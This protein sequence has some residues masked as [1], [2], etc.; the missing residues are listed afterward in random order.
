MLWNAESPEQYTLLLET[1]DECICQKIGLRKIEIKDGVVYLNGVAIKFRGVNRH[2]SDPVTGAAISREQALVDLALMKRHNINAIR[3][4]HYPN[5]PWFLQ[6][7]SEYGF[8]VIA[9]A[10][11]ESHGMADQLGGRDALE[12][13]PDAADDPQFKEAILDRARRSVIRDKNNAAVV[14]WSLG[15]E[16]GWGENFEVAGRWVKSYD[17]SRLLHYENFLTYHS[18]RKPDISMIDLYSRMYPSVQFVEDYFSGCELDENLEGRR[19]PLI[20]CEYVHAMGNGPGD[21]EDYQQLIMEHDGFCGGFVWE[22]CDHAVYGGTTSD[23]R[24]IYRYGGDFGEYPHDGNFCMDGL[25]Y[26]DRTPHRGLL[27]YKNCIRP[28]RVREAQEPNSFILHNYLDFT[29]AEDFAQLSYEVMQDGEILYGGNIDM[30]HIPPHGEARIELFDLP[31]DGIA[32]VTFF[33]TA[34]KDGDF[35]PAGHPL[36]FDE[37]I[38]SDEPFFLDEPVQGAVSVE[39]SARRISVFS[40]GFRYEFDKFTGLFESMV[41]K[42]K[43]LLTRPMQWNIY[44][45]PTDND[46]LMAPKWKA[47]GYDRATVKVYDTKVSSTENGVQISLHA[48]IAAVAIKRIV[49][50]T[51]CFKID[52]QGRVDIS[53]ECS[54]DTRMPFLPRFGIRLFMPKSFSE[55]EY[56]GWGP[57]ESYVDKHRASRL[58]IYAQDI[59]A[60]HENYLKPQENSSHCGCRY[61]SVFDGDLTFVA[62]AEE[63]FSFNASRYTQEEL[64]LKAHSYEI[65]P[66]GDTVLCLDGR[67]SGVG[68]N[69]C[70][71]E[72]LEKYQLN[73]ESFSFNITLLA[74]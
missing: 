26:P 19:P 9:E 36:G 35:Y 60:M 6:M 67:M 14:I 28:L 72:L 61:V 50:I 27:E 37:I 21:I 16:S 29:N 25:V 2:D 63:S 48:G 49:D 62:Q 18:D 58:G 38:L 24:P 68:S 73:E 13:Y 56:F 33:Y 42:N 11:M 39:E 3:T 47:V 5:S 30:P 34:K 53:M 23:N 64:S 8:Y 51:A 45:A 44:R 40:E 22:W 66:C 65:E 71:P 7:C 4:S 41:V 15:N 10:D 43:S 1:E 55:V 59:R 17:P 74:D 20:L 31:D 52:A 54:R 57:Y 70:G 46:R 69:S 12:R 32:T